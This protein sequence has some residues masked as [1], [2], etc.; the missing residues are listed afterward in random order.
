[1]CL[2]Y[3]L[4]NHSNKIN[5][6]IQKSIPKNEANYIV[7]VLQSLDVNFFCLYQP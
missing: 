3:M 7:I 5:D 4:Y 1:M 6:K 2:F